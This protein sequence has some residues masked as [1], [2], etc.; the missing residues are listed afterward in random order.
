MTDRHHNWAGNITFAAAAIHTPASVAEI[1]QLVR[2]GGG[3]RAVGSRHSFNTIADT[4]AAQVS[5]ERM[6]SVVGFD[7]E[8]QTITVEA[9]A[10]Y[11]TI[12]RQIDAAGYA[13]HNL[14]SLPHISVA[15]AVA[16][17]TH[18]SGV[19]NGN[20][21]TAVRGIELV[22]AGGEIVSLAR[23]DDGFDG[24]VVALGALGV[25]TKLTLDLLPTFD[26]RQDV[27][28]NLPMA[29]LEANFDA[30]MRGGYS[31]SLF[32]TWR[33]D[34]IEQI[35]RKR[36]VQPEVEV[37]VE[38]MFYGATAATERRHPLP[39][40]SAEPC[41]EQLGIAGPWHA[42]LPHFRMEF[43]PSSGEELQTE[44]FVPLDRAVDALR[45]VGGL[46]EVI[47]PLLQ[48]SELRAVAA[49]A[50]WLSM[51]HG[52]DSLGIHFTWKQDWEGVRRVLPQ[53]EAALAPFGVRP[54]WG[55]LFTMEQEQVRSL[56]PRLPDFQRLLRSYDP[57]G[58][59]GN[60]FVARYIGG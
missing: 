24:V 17:G 25:V 14:A 59:F 32:T 6:A 53:I 36:V 1:Q 10:T 22:T 31:V 11:G 7:R 42:R 23:G 28:E 52:R 48:T 47:A 39:G 35:W 9:G 46:R 37:E 12:V 26:V 20:L 13:L 16:T 58:Q 41:T 2:R 21:A 38:P 34:V 60:A 27:Y 43:T 44:Y 4:E 8:Q 51:A 40:I 49:D 30:I 19:A 15:G 55:K 50:L 5:L 33:G 56:Y 45:A 54:H 57:D 18:G 29:Q 3:L